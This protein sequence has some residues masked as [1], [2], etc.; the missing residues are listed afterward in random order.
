[1]VTKYAGTQN[2][3]QL[4]HRILTSLVV[5]F[6]AGLVLVS[7]DQALERQLADRLVRSYEGPKFI[8]PDRPSQQPLDVNVQ[9]SLTGI[10]NVVR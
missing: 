3:N 1:V 5:I 9:Y 7:S 4:S 8:V 2:T 6:V 10:T